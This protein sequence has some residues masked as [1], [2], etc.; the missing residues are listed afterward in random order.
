MNA[1]L[2][3]R[4][5]K[6]RAAGVFDRCERIVLYNTETNAIDPNFTYLSNVEAE[7]SVL[8]VTRSSATLYTVP[9]IEPRTRGSWAKTVVVDSAGKAL[10]RALRGRVGVNGWAMPYRIT[11]KLKARPVDVSDLL[12]KARATKTLY[13]IDK[14]RASVREARKILNSVAVRIGRKETAVAADLVY[15][16]LKRGHRPSFEPIVATGANT[17]SPHHVPTGARVRGLCYIDFGVKH[18]LYCSDLTRCFVFDR[19]YE[20][21]VAHVQ[22][23]L[24]QLENHI[25]PGVR[26]SDLH[27][28]A[29]ELLGKH[30][31]HFVHHLGH[32]IGLEVHEAPHVGPKSNDMLEAG[33]TIAIE[34]A[35]YIKNKFGVRIENDYLVTKK[36]CER[37]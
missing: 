27:R 25:K 2:K 20:K 33:M 18:D 28:T 35:F 37:L 26:A 14:I 8:V 19:R 7:Y 22:H 30:A 29:E 6:L 17:A 31:K 15:G 34:P 16:T 21:H 36:G 11:K 3:I 4:L 9:M 24:D 10:R 23:V 12:E 13:E 32:G 1:E 5:K